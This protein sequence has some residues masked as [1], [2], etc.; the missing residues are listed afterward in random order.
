MIAGTPTTLAIVSPS[1]TE[2][3][4]LPRLPGPSSSEA[5]T[6]ATPK[7]APCGR[8]ATNRAATTSP[9]LGSSAVATVASTN[10]TR[11]ESS[12]VLRG[13]RAPTAASTGAPT[14]T[15]AAYAETRM[16]AWA[17]ASSLDAA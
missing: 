2:V 11:S 16:P 15:P 12:T 6:V 17:I 10:T 4:A 5:A 1:S 8:P 13:S 7:Y 3:A 9:K 14:T